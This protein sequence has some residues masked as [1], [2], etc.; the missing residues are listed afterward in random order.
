MKCKNLKNKWCPAMETVADF[1]NP[2]AIGLAVSSIINVKTGAHG[3]GVRYTVNR[4]RQKELKGQYLFLNFCPF[5][6]AD[7]SKR[8]ADVKKKKVKRGQA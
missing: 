6:G 2:G 7:I 4:K 3:Y 1:G 8:T 5:C